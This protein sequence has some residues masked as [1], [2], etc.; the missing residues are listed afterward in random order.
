VTSLI[1]LLTN[2]TPLFEPFGSLTVIVGLFVLAW[3]VSRFAGQLAAWLVDRGERRR[4]TEPAPFDTGVIASLKQRQ[5]AISLI[6]TS[7]RYLA[8]GLAIV[9]SVAVAVGA[10]RI[11]T[12]VGASFLAIVVAFATQRFL[13]DVIAGLLMFFEGWFRVGDTVTIEPWKIQGVVEEVSVRSIKIRGIDG[14][15]MRV[16]NSSI[17]AMRVTPRGVRQIEIELYVSDLDRGLELIG[18]AVRLVPIGPTRFV[19]RPGV[20]ETERLDDDLYRITVQAA[21]PPGREWLADDFLPK[22]IHERAPEGVVIHGPV[23]LRSD[24]QAASRFAQ[25]E[26]EAT[27]PQRTRYTS[28]WRRL[29]RR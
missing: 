20:R 13:T 3:I 16:P 2:H 24:T 14:D 19:S 1:H 7:V 11:D 6:Q 18:E 10:R 8:F 4:R 26:R 27:A 23:V 9:L 12:I 17:N 22:L 28:V 29:R 21:V 5:T 25:V 15:V